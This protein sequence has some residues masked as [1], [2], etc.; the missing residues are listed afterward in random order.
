MRI[1]KRS[2]PLIA[3]AILLGVATVLVLFAFDV[4]GWQQALGSGDAH[5]LARP[6]NKPFWKSSSILPGD[7]VRPLLDL[8][9][10]LTYREAL[11]G[12]WVNEVGTVKSKG[13]DL[14]AARVAAQT[15][16][17]RLAESGRT[18]EE[19]SSAANLLGVMTITTTATDAATLSQL[20]INAAQDFQQ[21][22][23][24]DST[25]WPAKVNLE[26]LLLLTRPQKSKFGADA[27]GGFGSG[28]SVGQGVIGGGF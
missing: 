19:R 15:E 9:D 18:A 24:L 17:E 28:G 2:L 27:R 8:G 16:L 7:P 10:A 3:A 14:S 22:V 13:E 11:Q 25:D 23:A 21:A 6:S 20:L 5:F 4:R 1:L 26:L 12:F